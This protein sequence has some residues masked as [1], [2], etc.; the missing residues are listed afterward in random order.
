MNDSIQFI[1]G[2]LVIV[3]VWGA[4]SLRGVNKIEYFKTKTGKGILKGILLA[5]AFAVLFA[6]IPDS[7]A[8]GSWFN[9]AEVFAGLDYTKKPNPMCI[10]NTIDNKSG[11]NLGLKL[12]IYRNENF[13]LNSKY[14]HHSCAFG[15]DD[16]SYDALG[17]ELKYKFWSK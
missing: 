15:E 8:Q 16:K 17:L 4:I 7:K 13:S 12:N 5:I 10:G 3:L 1:L 14:T 6:L 11:S 2:I 9:D